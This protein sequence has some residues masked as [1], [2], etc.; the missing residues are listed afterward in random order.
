VKV[1][2][3]PATW[4]LAR[5]LVTAVILSGPDVVDDVDDVD[6][7]EIANV[8]VL[9]YVPI[10]EVIVESRTQTPTW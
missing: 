4:G 8:M 10:S 7:G 3:V 6:V 2:R 9:L 5:L 1:T